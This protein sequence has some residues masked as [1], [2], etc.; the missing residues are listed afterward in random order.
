MK[1]VDKVMLPFF[2]HPPL[3]LYICMNFQENISPGFI[4]TDWTRFAYG[5]LQRGIIT[6]KCRQSYGAYSVHIV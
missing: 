6:L 3:T 1:T 2:A 5:N 4:V